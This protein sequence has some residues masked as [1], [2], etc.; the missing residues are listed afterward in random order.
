MYDSD[1]V[2]FFMQCDCYCPEHILKIYYSQD[3]KWDYYLT[4]DYF[5]VGW[6]NV[7]KRMW[8]AL[9]YV[10]GYKSKYGEFGEMIV[11]PQTALKLKVFLDTYLSQDDVQK[12]LKENPIT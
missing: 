12:D 2:E 9:K 6:N 4:F 10:F 3:H 8:I 7:F 1:L 11:N 5:L